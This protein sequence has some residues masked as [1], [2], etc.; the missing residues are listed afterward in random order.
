MALQHLRSGTANKRPIATAMSDGQLAVNTN[1]DSPGLFFKNSNGDLVKVGPV[2]IGSTAPNASPASTAATALVSGTAYQILTVGTS[3]FTTVGAGSNAV[4]VVF[5][6]SGTTTGTGTVSGQQGNERGEMWLDNTGGRY[7]LKIYDGTAWRSEADEF[8]NATGD[9]MTGDLLFNNANIVFEGSAAD[10]HETTLTVANPTADRTI[11]LPNVTGT[12]LTTGDTGSV[13][14]A[15]IVDGTIVNA[16]VNAS[17]AIGLSKLATGAL[18]T[19]ITVASANIVDG[20]IVNADINASAA[21]AGT[22]V[23]PDFGSQAITTTG[24]INA[25]GKV[26]FPLGSES[27]PS[28][29]PGSDTNTGIFSPGADSLAITTSGTQ[30][31]VVDSSG[32]VHIGGTLPSAPNISLNANGGATFAGVVTAPTANSGTNTTQVATT[33]FVTAAV[34]DVSGKANLASP[35]FTGTPAAPTASSGTNTTQIATTAFVTA[36]VPNV[37]GKADLASPTFTG[38]PAAPTASGGT[39]TTQL[40]TTAFVTA[41]VPDVSGKANLASPTFTG[42]PA[43]PTAGSGTST[44]Q[45]ATTAFV[46][47]SPTFTGTP[48]AP[49]A[50]SGTNTTQLATTAFVT[51]A[52]AGGG[53]SSFSTDIVVNSLTVGR[54]AGNVSSN[55]AFGDDALGAS[56]SGANNVGVGKDALSSL[57]S[58]NN[59]TALGKDALR[60]NTASDLVAVGKNAL[61][62]NTTGGSNAGFGTGAL[63][64]NT[65]GSGNLAIGIRAGDNITTGSQNIVIGTDA[66]ASTATVSNEITLGSTAINSLRIPGLQ[67]GASDGDV[68]TYSSSAGKITLAAASGGGGGGGAMEY[69]STTTISAATANVG[70]DLSDANYDFFVLKAY[71]CKFTATPTNG[72]CVYFNF[73]DGAYNPSSVGTNRMSFLYQRN[74]LDGSTIASSSAYSHNLTLFLGWTPTTSANFGFSAEVGGKTNSPVTINSNFLEGTSTSSGCPSAAGVAP[75]SSNNMTYMTVMPSTTTFAAGTFLLYG[76]KNS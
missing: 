35:T 24:I 32:D 72:Y 26:S 33:A 54:G 46:T 8:V 64:T 52:V 41:A 16:D 49:T 56:T 27:A 39:N 13:T 18:P 74:R 57:T 5:T 23:S 3:D 38:T 42:V 50:G 48:A 66:D 55:T 29:L 25:N 20:S 12:V 67:A 70:F 11:T 73:Y 1:L 62:F 19:G 37:S 21:I 6:A 75:N 69:I 43:A 58:G 14:S 36:A 47:A 59:C 9:T 7:V 15:M 71:G 51:A 4:G 2:H 60:S 31:V 76:I 10:E 40:A 17:A 28:L 34:P 30:R 61:Y 65:T 53:G 45:I 68:L 22:K 63:F 44:T